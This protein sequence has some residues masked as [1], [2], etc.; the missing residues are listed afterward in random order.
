MIIK[1]FMETPILNNPQQIKSNLWI[2][3]TIWAHIIILNILFFVF[4]YAL[5]IFL[6]IN[7]LNFWIYIKEVLNILILLFAIWYGLRTVFKRTAVNPENYLWISFFAVFPSLFFQILIVLFAI[8]AKTEINILGINPSLIW[9]GIF[10][11]ILQDIVV[12]ISVFYFLKRKKQEISV[13]IFSKYTLG[14]IVFLLLAVSANATTYYFIS[15]WGQELFQSQDFQKKLISISRPD[16]NPYYSISLPADWK[17]EKND[18]GAGLDKRLIG[19]TYGPYVNLNCGMISLAECDPIAPSTVNLSVFVYK[20]IKRLN[21]RDYVKTLYKSFPNPAKLSNGFVSTTFEIIPKTEIRGEGVKITNYFVS[22]DRGYQ[23]YFINSDYIYWILVDYKFS[24]ADMEKGIKESYQKLSEEYQLVIDSLIDSFVEKQAV[25]VTENK[26]ANWQTYQN[27]KYGFEFTAP[28]EWKVS[29]SELGYDFDSR[30]DNTLKD[31]YYAQFL[32][33]IYNKPVPLGQAIVCDAPVKRNI[34]LASGQN[35]EVIEQAN[36]LLPEDRDKY[37]G[38]NSIEANIKLKNGKYLYFI[39]GSGETP[40]NV[41]YDIINVFE[42]IKLY[43]NIMGNLAYPSEGNPAQEVCAVNIQNSNLKFCIDTNDGQDS[44]N[45]K[46]PD[47]EYYVYTSLKKQMGDFVPAYRAYYNQFVLCGLET[48]CDD[49]QH[50]KTF[51]PVKIENS[52]TAENIN[53][54]DWYDRNQLKLIK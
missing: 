26:T 12:F 40:Q 38:T 31:K 7:S 15:K 32:M 45:L 29:S 1:K 16:E 35:I 4:I 13:E 44:F 11:L 43:G 24:K 19:Y 28:K 6:N 51:I 53:P 41:Y 14:F 46:V 9:L 21:I 48:K 27:D 22:G 39:G 10:S 3:L 20:N 42:S 5:N 36:C 17:I 34:N 33:Q 50:H 25:G 18:I 8:F 52:K 37:R 47:G 49:D 54:Y 23:Y 2:G 30:T